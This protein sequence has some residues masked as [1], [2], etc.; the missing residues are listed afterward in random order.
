MSR[1]QALSAKLT[2]VTLVSGTSVEFHGS[3]RLELALASTMVYFQRTPAPALQPWVR[4]LWYCRA[5]SVSH[6]HERVLPNGCIQI[7]LN[8]ARDHLTDC[9]NDLLESR[10]PPAIVVGARQC[11]ELIATKDLT[12]LAGIVV[13]PGGFA[14]LFRTPADLLFQRSVAAHDL[15]RG[16]QLDWILEAHTPATKLDAL[17][18]MLRDTVG[19]P[20]KRS[21]LVDGA[22]R[23][24]G[25]PNTSVRDCAK[26]A[27]VS[28]RR[29]SQIFRE[30]VGISP[31]AWCRIQRFQIAVRDLHRGT[32]VSWADLALR[33]GYYDQSH[34][35]NDFRAFSGIN[36]TTYATLRG[37]WQNH[38]RV[39]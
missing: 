3:T 10:L 25:R 1:A 8:L 30:Q 4:S 21:G 13:E 14:G 2:N 19:E 37:H 26:S 6:T 31:K 28:E 7:V 23:F 24:L 32:E 33:C 39:S 22:L 12:E 16:F 9:S 36:P 27:A 11:Y 29:L 34:F 15:W 5:P 35:I 18:K 17:E 20:A 38:V